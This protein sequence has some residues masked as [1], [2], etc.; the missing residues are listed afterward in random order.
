M[1][2]DCHTLAIHR[3]RRD[4]AKTI[5]SNS[6]ENFLATFA[7]ACSNELERKGT[8]VPRPA[9]TRP[10]ELELEILKALWQSSPA[11]VRQVQAALAP[12]RPLATTSV[13]TVLNI[14]T[15]KGYLKRSKSG[16]VYVYS[17]TVSETATANGMI[18]DL[19]NRLFRG[20][21][22]SLMLN[23]ISEQDLDEKTLKEIRSAL[24]R[25]KREDR[26]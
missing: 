23:L 24:N 5:F 1:R 6:L 7:P 25:K 18:G 15:R 3:Q 9:S 20:S 16:A 11:N 17:P 22:A 19:I 8:T 14:M 26:P 10:T 4:Q 2:L 12:T 13:T 21:A